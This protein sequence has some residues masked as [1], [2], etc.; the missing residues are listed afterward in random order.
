MGCYRFTLSFITLVKDDVK[1]TLS[2]MKF[3][4]FYAKMLNI[5]SNKARQIRVLEF[6][7]QGQE[8]IRDLADGEIS[9]RDELTSRRVDFGT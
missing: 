3:G 4:P 5:L 2:T 6:I 8:V 1:L 7:V 9:L